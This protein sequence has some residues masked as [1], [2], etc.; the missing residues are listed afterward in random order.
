M[1]RYFFHIHT[2]DGQLIQDEVGVEIAD[3]DVAAG[4]AV[5]T[6]RSFAMDTHGD[7][8]YSGCYFEIRGETGSLT[9]PAL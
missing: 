3:L 5:E 2:P 4:I 9:L 1:P 7:F 6:A 8:D